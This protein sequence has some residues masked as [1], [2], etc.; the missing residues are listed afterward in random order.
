MEKTSLT[1]QEIQM[2]IEELDKKID[3]MTHKIR[4]YLFNKSKYPIPPPYEG[5]I[6]KIIRHN[7]DGR[8]GNNMVVQAKLENLRYKALL[9]GRIWRQWI[10]DA[11][12]MAAQNNKNKH[13][14][15]QTP[16]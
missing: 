10:L 11:E 14:Q 13:V 4:Q 2:E 8:G 9:R 16:K 5:L 12:K 6:L 3:D 15:A 1:I 7:Y